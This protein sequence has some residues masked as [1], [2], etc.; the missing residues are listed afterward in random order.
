MWENTEQSPRRA[1]LDWLDDSA[2]F[3][4]LLILIFASAWVGHM[5]ATAFGACG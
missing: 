5:L 1:W 2:I 4:G 3:I